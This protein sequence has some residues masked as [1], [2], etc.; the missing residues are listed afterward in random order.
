M[1]IINARFLTQ[2]LTGVQRF[3]IEISK[4]VKKQLGD[5]VRFVSCPD[6]LHNALFDELD[7]MV[8][9]TKKGHLWEQIDLYR[10]LLKNNKPLLVS[11]GYTGP[12]F[13]KNQIVSIHDVAFIYYKETFSKS[14]ALA[15]NFLVPRIAKRCQH[16]FTVSESAKKEV[17][18]ELEIA[19]DKV[20]VVYNGISE[21]FTKSTPAELPEKNNRSYVLTVS[22]HHPRKNYARLIEAFNS[23]N[24]KEVDLYIIG[25]VVGHFTTDEK[26]QPNDNVK[27]LKHITDEQLVAYYKNASLFVFPSLYEGFGIPVIEAMSQNIPCV[28]SD[29][30]VFREIGDDSVIYVNPNAVDSIRNGIIKGLE[31]T[32]RSIVYPKLNKFT[33]FNSAQEVIRI[34]E[35]Y[36]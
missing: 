29:I 15:Y 8:I 34:I 20:T 5:R 4:Q 9:G 30:P 7:A 19:A 21:T 31:L 33:W 22:S 24:N 36:N 1:I 16:V 32:S 23:L 6:V 10:F 11:F 3:A 18:K 25:N 14:F 26:V 2:P 28:L 27:F 35:K 13:Y 17:C 12:L